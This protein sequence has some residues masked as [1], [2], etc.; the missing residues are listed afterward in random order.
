M[1]YVDCKKYAMDILDRV[2]KRSIK[3]K[4]VIIMVGDDL[5]SE[6]YVKGKLKDCE[7]CGVPYELVALDV[8]TTTEELRSVIN[9]Y[10]FDMSV[11]GIIVQQPLPR[12]IDTEVIINEILPDLDVDG[13]TNKSPF[14]PCT[15]EGI[16]HILKKELGELDGLNALIIGRG[17]L[18]GMPM[19]ACLLS[20][21]CTVTI[22][23][24]HTK[25]LYDLLQCNDI[26]VSA[27]GKPKLVDL[28]KC[29]ARIVV[30]VGVNRDENGKLCGDCYNFNEHD[31]SNMLVTPVPGGIG[32]MTRAM[33]MKHMGGHYE[34]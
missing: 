1:K 20:A 17:S 4:L 12:H 19:L 27:A 10:N 34:D 14:M 8:R 23:H 30:D 25:N 24:S 31:D 13:F 16:M 15:P 28:A 2:R 3:N 32:L 18:V 11:N 9:K 33:L 21:N 26:V 29:K 7:Y 6:S 22:A 5:A